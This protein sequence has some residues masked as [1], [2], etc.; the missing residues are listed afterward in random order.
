M[1]LTLCLPLKPAV[2]HLSSFSLISD[3]D[4]DSNHP[5][6]LLL[7]PLWLYRS[8]ADIPSKS[9]YL[10]LLDPI[11]SA[12]PTVPCKV[13]VTGVEDYD[14]DILELGGLCSQPHIIYTT[15]LPERCCGD[16][17]N[18]ALR[19]PVTE[20]PAAVP[21]NHHYKS[22]LTGASHSSVCTWQGYQDW[23][24]SRG[25]RGPLTLWQVPLTQGSRWLGWTFLRRSWPPKILP[26]ILFSSIPL[27]STQGLD[28]HVL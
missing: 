27:S 13:T 28:R 8:H 17:E 10:T 21:W 6:S 23:P 5:A 11:T 12:K 19:S 2:C 26:P 18:I 20:H 3:S 9:P 25:H 1:A 22:K 15:V 24:F 16:F 4:S 7:G 14:V